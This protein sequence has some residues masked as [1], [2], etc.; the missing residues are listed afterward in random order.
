VLSFKGID[1]AAYYRLVADHPRHYYDTTGTGNSLN[2]RHPRSLQLIMDSLR[3]WVSEMHVDGFR[4]DL[5]ATLARQFHEVDRLS[6]FF[7]LIQQD[8]IVSQVKL[9]A[10][11][12]D[13]GEG[14]Y[15]V[16]NFPPVWSE[17]N[18]KY[19]DT[20]RDFWRGEHATLPELASRLTGSSDLYQ[21]DTRRPA[22]SINFVTAH[23]GFTLVDLVAYNGKHNEASGEDNNDGESHN[24]SWN[25]GVEGPTDDE[26]V[27][28]WR[29]LLQR[30]FLATLFLSQGVPMLLGG[31][32]MSRTQSGNNNAYCQDNE[33]S[34]FDWES[35]DS[36]LRDFAKRL[37][38]LRRD[39]PV[40]RRRH[41]FQDRP[42]R[43]TVDIG[44]FRPDG[45]EMD[46]ADWA[47]DFARSVGLLL[48]GET[49]AERDP[50]GRRVVDESFLLI[51]NA[52]DERLDWTLPVQWGDDWRVVLDTS[53]ELK[54]DEQ[55]DP[56]KP[57]TIHGRA[58]VVLTS[59][60]STT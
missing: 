17:W 27:R 37:I 40:F 41:W 31:D 29:E 18:G 2:V 16:G 19:R 1:N 9:I 28:A 32:E 6:A 11:P 30:N 21:A 22:A 48:N 12:W 47:A 38:A 53:D 51:L 43:G 55:P 3:Y 46:D 39:H 58:V 10:E 57:L 35:A 5:A 56:D 52:H 59:P 26:H 15:H 49:L 20:V 54:A 14:G 24:R 50:R 44:W 34:W 33:I 25:G 36:R 8:P 45:G 42:I 23:D 4:F 7:D 13:I 60:R